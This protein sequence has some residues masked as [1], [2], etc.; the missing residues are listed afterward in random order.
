MLEI[1]KKY[2]YISEN[3]KALVGKLAFPKPSI[4][5]ES[6]LKIEPEIAHTIICEDKVYQTLFSQSATKILGPNKI[7]FQ[8]LKMI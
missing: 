2:C 8:I 4:N 7:N 3:K 1:Q 5:A 6:D